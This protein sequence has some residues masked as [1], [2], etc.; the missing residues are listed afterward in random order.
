[1]KEELKLIYKKNEMFIKYTIISIICTLIMFGLY[2]LVDYLTN[3]K[4]IIANIIAY[5]VSFTLIFILNR[6]L[7][8][9]RPISRRNKIRQLN[10]FI[11][12]RCIGLLIDSYLLSILIE[13][14]NLTN[15][16]GKF[17]SSLI[18]FMYNYFTNKAFIFNN[19]TF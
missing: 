12:F 5:G 11:I 16:W 3:G 9:S 10:N 1:M 2:I 6:N 4:Y 14:F 13:E 8:N 18:T 7:F 19:K 17:F 15:F